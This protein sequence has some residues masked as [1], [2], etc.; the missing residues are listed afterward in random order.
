MTLSAPRHLL[1]RYLRRLRPERGTLDGLVD[2]LQTLLQVTTKD[3][4]LF[5]AHGLEL[6]VQGMGADLAYL[7]TV[8][9]G[10]FETQWWSPE[11]EG[12]DPPQ[13]VPSMCHWL[14][15]NPYRNLVLREIATDERWNDD[16][17]FE[18]L[19]IRAVAGVT[20]LESGQVKGLVFCQYASPHPFTRAE[21]ALF[22]A[23]AGFLGRV[24]E[25]ENLKFALS[26]LE[27]ALAITKA[28]V[29]DSS[30]H[31]STCGLPN[32][33][34]LDIWL[35]ANLAGNP[36]DQAV[37]TVAEWHLPMANRAESVRIREVANYVRGSDLVV[38]GGQGRFLLF[39]QRTPK[40]LGHIFLLRLRHKL[41]IIPMGATLWIPGVDDIHMESVQSRLHTALEESRAQPQPGL[42]WHL[43]E[44]HE[45][46]T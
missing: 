2:A 8:S 21:L 39:L 31:D 6:L 24:L 34:Y 42:V 4:P 7:V 37:M 18:L 14:V 45:N 32:L 1:K 11:R 43:P 16:P 33:R 17:A 35:K 20:L 44:E 10:G 46:A 9:G 19:N 23:V 25:V 3:D 40:G 5:L 22:N 12:E 30:I 26:R 41:G 36:K 15:D 28:V 27:N 29:E 38:S 13:H